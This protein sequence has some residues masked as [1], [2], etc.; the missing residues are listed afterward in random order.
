VGDRVVPVLC[1]EAPRRY[2][3]GKMR[4]VPVTVSAVMTVLL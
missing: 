1:E 4:V 3:G 2:R